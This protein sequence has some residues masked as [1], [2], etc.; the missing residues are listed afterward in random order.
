MKLICSYTQYKPMTDEGLH[1]YIPSVLI[2]LSAFQPP[3]VSLGFIL[4]E[5]FNDDFSKGRTT[6]TL[7]WAGRSPRCYSLSLHQ[8]KTTQ[9]H[10]LLQIDPC[11]PPR[12]IHRTRLGYLQSRGPCTGSMSNDKGG[13]ALQHTTMS[14]VTSSY[15]SIACRVCQTQRYPASAN[16]H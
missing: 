11:I 14:P 13:F 3:C 15:S 16:P 2:F 10:S 7:V 9:S 4:V 12:S 8:L 5:P 6:R 1:T